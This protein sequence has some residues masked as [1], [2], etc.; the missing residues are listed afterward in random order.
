[1]VRIFTGDND[2]AIKRASRS[3]IDEFIEAHGDLA[4]ERFDAE[5]AN[6]AAIADAIMSMPFLA[7][8][9]MVVISGTA[10]KELMEQLLELKVPDSTEVIIIATK[11]DK[12]ASYYKKASK[13]PGFKSFEVKNV[14]NLPAWVSD[15]VA[16]AGG[17]ISA[18]DARFLVEYTGSNQLNLQ[19]E[20]EKLVLFDQKVTRATIEELCDPSPQSTVFQLVDAVFAGNYQKA[21][22]IYFEQRAQKVEPYAIMGMLAWQLHILALVKA[23]GSKSPDTIAKEAKLSPYV[24]KK[25]QGIARRLTMAQIKRF[26]SDAKDLDIALKSQ[27]INADDAMTTYLL[28]LAS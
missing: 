23:A 9:K 25:T 22:Q 14:T 17:A 16:A 20:I 11:L 8:S 28:K 7:T 13:L 27:P 12:R 10:N 24:V 2:F 15:Q 4:L 1:M 6:V 21:E 5:D 26:V 3:Y 18:A 19:N